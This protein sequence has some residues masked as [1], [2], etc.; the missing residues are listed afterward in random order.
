MPRKLIELASEIVLTQVSLKPMS[1]AEI[2][3]YL[4]Q[5]FS[6]LHT[7]QKA[8]AAGIHL[9]LDQTAE[10]ISLEPAP[11]PKIMPAP[12]DSIQDDKV[13]CLECSAE[14][15][16]LTSKHLV[17]HGMSQKEYKMKYG[18][19]MRT[20]LAAKSLTRARSNA[21]K[22]NGLPENLKKFHEEKRKEK[23]AASAKAAP[24]SPTDNKH[25]RTILRKKK[26]V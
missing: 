9:E 2:V 5:V 15:K 12:Q 10:G 21:A 7:L 20:P 26:A 23:A 8:E 14:M 25:R 3:S 18:F 11:K 4:R 24:A 1:S 16:Q 22:K 19:T 13:I 6:T 17:S